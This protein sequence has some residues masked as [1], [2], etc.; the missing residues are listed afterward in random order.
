[1]AEIP[2]KVLKML[3]KDSA[4]KAAFIA[5]M[6]LVAN[7]DIPY[8]KFLCEAVLSYFHSGRHPLAF[9]ILQSAIEKFP[10]NKVAPNMLAQL[11]AKVGRNEEAIVQLRENLCKFPDDEVAPTMLAQLL[12]NKGE[13][14][15]AKGILEKRLHD[16]VAKTMYASQIAREGDFRN[17]LDLLMEVFQQEFSFHALGV[18]TTLAR[19]GIGVKEHR[20]IMQMARLGME[21]EESLKPYIITDYPLVADLG[22]Y[23]LPA[24][25]LEEI[26]EIFTRHSRSAL[27]VSDVEINW[28]PINKLAATVVH[29]PL[30]QHERRDDVSPQE[31]VSAR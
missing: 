24:T 6:Y 15:E 9:K 10:D 30:P 1:M 13:R 19:H 14:E 7:P 21:D 26:D 4:A 3:R 18:L 27:M 31:M 16:K 23:M 20:N 5:D 2:H 22:R 25:A 17:C 11:L 8:P 28:Q 12:F 29:K